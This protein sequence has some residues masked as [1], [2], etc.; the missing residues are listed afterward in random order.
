MSTDEFPSPD[1]PLECVQYTAKI[2]GYFS[3][4]KHDIH[5]ID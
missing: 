5:I 4:K 1:F 2:R 3:N